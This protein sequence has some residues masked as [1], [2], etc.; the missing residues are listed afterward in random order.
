[1]KTLFFSILLITA[2]LAFG[3]TKSE[4]EDWIKS[5]IESGGLTGT[6]DFKVYFEGEHLSIGNETHFTG[7]TLK[8]GYLIKVKCI[9]SFY[10]KEY[11]SSIHLIIKTSSNCKI[12]QN[13]FSNGTIEQVNQVEL[14]LDKSF[15]DND[16]KNRFTK[17]MNKLIEFY[18][19]SVTKEVY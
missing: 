4:T 2:Q 9:S 6:Q 12:Q 11:E 18:G 15:A 17:A 19:G 14:I 13:D 3:Q 16:M 8:M 5:K 10:F 1:M 7:F